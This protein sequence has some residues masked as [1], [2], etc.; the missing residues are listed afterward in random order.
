ML[1]RSSYSFHLAQEIESLGFRVVFVLPHEKQN[2]SVF[3]LGLFSEDDLG[4]LT[5]D[6]SVGFRKGD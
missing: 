1:F 5:V 4:I 3:I 2:F 6:L